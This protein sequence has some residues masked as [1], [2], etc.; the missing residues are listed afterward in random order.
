[1][2]FPKM[3]ESVFGIIPARGGSK[4]LPGK[5]L[6]KLAGMSLLERTISQAKK[7]LPVSV[8]TTEDT[9][10]TLEALRCGLHVLRRPDSLATDSAT[11]EDVINHA[12]NAYMSFK[13]FCLLQPTSPLRTVNDIQECVKWAIRENRSVVSVCDGRRNGAVYVGRTLTIP[14]LYFADAMYYEMPYERSI[15]ID[16]QEDFDEAERILNATEIRATP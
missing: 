11:S 16:T 4:R 6:K 1:M 15:D 9:Q 8:V 12:V 13:W 3:I 14:N 7:A 5:N 10:I 2:A